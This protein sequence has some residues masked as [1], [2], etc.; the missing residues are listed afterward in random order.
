MNWIH[1]ILAKY[2]LHFLFPYETITTILIMDNLCNEVIIKVKEAIRAK[3][4]EMNANSSDEIIDYIMLLVTTKKS[5]SELA[6]SIDFVMESNTNVFVKWLSTIIK[7][8][9]QVTV[10]TTK[11]IVSDNFQTSEQN[12]TTNG[13]NESDDILECESNDIKLDNTDEVKEEL[14]LSVDDENMKKSNREKHKNCLPELNVSNSVKY[15][16]TI[17]SP[18]SNKIRPRICFS[19]IEAIKTKHNILTNEKDIA[20]KPSQKLH[21]TISINSHVSKQNIIND[22]ETVDSK[23]KRPR[24]SINSDN[25]DEKTDMSKLPIATNETIKHTAKE[26]PKNN[27]KT[28][29]Q[30]I[31]VKSHSKNNF[32]ETR[33]KLNMHDL[34]VQRVDHQ[35]GALALDTAF[36]YIQQQIGA[37]EKEIAVIKKW[38]DYAVDMLRSSKN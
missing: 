3:L 5:S 17:I 23:R 33:K 32:N 30:V 26:L 35:R 34:I 13:I 9:Q 21:P 18:A 1:R 20:I 8:L 36:K 6:K 2:Q 28:M 37:T 16:E 25:E 12:I 7:K 29:S 24:I 38:R 19:S 27:K 14:N 15:D 22:N 31:V 4:K 11:Q 10:S